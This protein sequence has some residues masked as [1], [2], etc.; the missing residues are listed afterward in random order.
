M[1]LNPLP[2]REHSETLEQGDPNLLPEFVNLAEL[3]V[4]NNSEIGS[5]SAT[6]YYQEIKDAINRVNKVF[7]DTILNRIYTN[8]GRARLFGFELGIDVNPV[9]WWKIYLGGNVYHYQIEGSLFENSVLVNNSSWQYSI[10][11]NTNFQITPTLN[12]Q[13]NLNYLS[14]RVTA[15]GKDSRFIIP[16]LSVKQTFLNGMLYAMLQWQNMDLGL[17]GTN[18]QRITT[19]GID[20]YT[21]TNYILETDMFLLNVGFNLNELS[22]KSKL[23]TSEFGDKEF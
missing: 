18:Q 9:K 6:F 5:F 17:L 12:I 20:F 8:A 1:Q 22:K 4:I 7:A 19:S 2:E 3:G 16:N 23:P 21:T 15:Q 10:N 11:A 14:E 13:W